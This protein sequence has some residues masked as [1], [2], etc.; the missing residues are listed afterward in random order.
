MVWVVL[1]GIIRSLIVCCGG[2]VK[3]LEAPISWR[4]K[5]TDVSRVNFFSSKRQ[6]KVS[7]GN[8]TP[9]FAF[10]FWNLAISSE[11]WLCCA[12]PQPPYFLCG[13]LV[14]KG[15]LSKHPQWL[16]H[17]AMQMS[18]DKAETAVHTYY[19][20]QLIWLCACVPH[21]EHSWK[22]ASLLLL[23]LLYSVLG[24]PH[25]LR[26]SAETWFHNKLAGMIWLAHNRG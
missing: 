24:V 5:L 8:Q 17:Y 4:R 18:S 2:W 12:Q 23:T 7:L 10:V 11:R 1:Q 21:R 16:C 20:T 13:Q 6:L 14:L 22:H 15:V 3:F 26:L 25:T 19:V 9:I